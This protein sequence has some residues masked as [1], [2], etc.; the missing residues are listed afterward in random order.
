MGRSARQLR[1]HATAPADLLCARASIELRVKTRPL[2][3]VCATRTTPPIPPSRLARPDETQVSP[4]ILLQSFSGFANGLV[5][6]NQFYRAFIDL[7][8][9]TFYFSGPFCRQSSIGSSIQAFPEGIG[10][11]GSLFGRQGQSFSLDLFQCR[12]HAGF[13]TVIRIVPVVKDSPHGVRNRIP[14]EVV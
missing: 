1:P 3:L 7:R 11:S 9:T 12:T 10:Q 2:I 6:W 4:S 14:P 8:T 5:P 13:K